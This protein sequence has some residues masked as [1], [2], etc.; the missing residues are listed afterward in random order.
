MPSV[1]PSMG[2]KLTT[3]RSRPE[4]RL[5]V[6]CSVN[7]ATQSPQ[8][9]IFS[10]IFCLPADLHVTADLYFNMF[11]GNLE[12]NYY[13]FSTEFHTRVSHLSFFLFCISDPHLLGL[14]SFCLKYI[15]RIAFLKVCW[16]QIFIFYL[17]MSLFCPNSWKIILPSLNF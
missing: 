8:L 7:W 13:K 3:L 9:K 10:I 4:L 2:P 5:R 1:E 12:R 6:G 17:K 16:Y 15:H 11:F 14:R